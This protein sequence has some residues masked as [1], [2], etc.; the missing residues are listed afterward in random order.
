M[1]HHLI[2][3]FCKTG[4][5]YKKKHSRSHMVISDNTWERSGQFQDLFC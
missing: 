4:S 2:M 3:K 1:V 5:M